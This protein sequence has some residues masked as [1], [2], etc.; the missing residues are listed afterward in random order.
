MPDTFDINWFGVILAT[1]VNMVLGS[2]WYSPYLFG[3]TWA[4]AQQMDIKSLV[5][6]PLHYA[7]AFLVSLLTAFVLAVLLHK[8]RISTYSDALTLAFWA[9]LG[10][11]ATTHFSGVLW[12]KRPLTSYLIDTGYALVSF[13]I[14]ALIL[15][16]L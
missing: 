2:L 14:L 3:K 10:F 8:F 16:T 13:L 6:T 4:E 9:W 11:V 12:A 1:L 5:A 7:G 15:V